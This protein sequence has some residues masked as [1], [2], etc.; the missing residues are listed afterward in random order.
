MIIYGLRDEIPYLL[1]GR[2]LYEKITFCFLGLDILIFQRLEIFLEL[3]GQFN[4]LQ[5][6]QALCPQGSAH[7]HQHGRENNERK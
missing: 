5:G 3:T 6:I 2:S 4:F 1:I 7:R